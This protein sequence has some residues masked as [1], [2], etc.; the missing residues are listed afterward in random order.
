MVSTPPPPVPKHCLA[1]YLPVQVCAH[2]D[3]VT[4]LD[5]F[6]NALISASE[7]GVLKVRDAW[8]VGNAAAHLSTK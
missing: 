5:S 1:L 4:T 8:Q 2:D 3:M 6:D 7:C